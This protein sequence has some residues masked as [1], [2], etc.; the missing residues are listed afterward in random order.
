MFARHR[1]SPVT[2]STTDRSSSELEIHVVVFHARRTPRA[3]GNRT[4]SARSP[5]MR[6]L[7]PPAATRAAAIAARASMRMPA[8]GTDTP[9]T[10]EPVTFTSRPSAVTFADRPDPKTVRPPALCVHERWWVPRTST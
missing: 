5:A 7:V 2:A 3:V 9:C 4:R 10:G 1:T 8:A 6:A